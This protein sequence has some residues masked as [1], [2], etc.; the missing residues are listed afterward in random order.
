LSGGALIIGSLHG[1][2][3]AEED[4]TECNRLVTL[5]RDRFLAHFATT[6]CQ[7]LRDGGFGSAGQWP[8]SEL[9]HQA[10]R[11]LWGVLSE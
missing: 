5:Y 2:A 6:R 10:V 9:V 4:D 11:I 1:R 7:D 3:S 8:C